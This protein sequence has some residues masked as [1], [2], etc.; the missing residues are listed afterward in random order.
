[1]DIARPDLAISRARRRRWIGVALAVAV[2]LVAW[3]LSRLEAAAPVVEKGAVWTDTVK[4]GD[5]LREVRG[6]GS[7]VPEDVRWLPALTEA[8]VERIVVQPGSRV[9]AQTVILEMSNPDLELG[10]LEAES[11]FRAAEARLVETRAR[12]ESTRLDQEANAQRVASEARQARLQADADAELARQGLAASIT[13]RVSMVR[14]EELESRAAVEKR[15]VELAAGSIDSHIAV[16]K[17][18]VEQRRAMLRLRRAQVEALRVRAGI[19]G[20]LQVVPVEVGQRVAPG[21]NLARVAEPTRLKA[22]IRIPETQARDVTIG[23]RCSVDTR[24]GVVGGRVARVDPAVQN[25][26]VAIDVT[27]EGPLPRG[28]RPDLTVDGVVELERL[29]GVLFVGRPAQAS[30]ESFAGLFRLNPATGEAVRVRVRLGRTSVNTV[31]I[32]E[33]LEAGDT[34]ILSDTSAWDAY[35]RLIVK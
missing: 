14:A 7:L 27:L 24:N 35:D 21:T 2:G 23:L 5:M 11:Q 18:D 3:G 15:R 25:G 19:D 34:L 32:R 28:A 10:A 29:T 8:R 33:G 22:V 13:A 4:R 16:A 12:V 9:L 6:L 20:V 26:T 31:E 30:A 1:M 17:A